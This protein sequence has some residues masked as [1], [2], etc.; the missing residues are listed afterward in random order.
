MDQV[1]AKLHSMHTQISDIVKK[2]MKNGNCKDRVLLW[3]RQAVALN[4]D[5]QKMFTQKPVASDGFILNYI[6]L[7]LILCKPF[8]GNFEKYPNFLSKINSFYLITDDW[9]PKG[10]SLEKIEQREEQKAPL[11]QCIQQ[12]DASLGDFSGITNTSIFSGGSSLMGDSQGG[13]KLAPPNFISDCF[14]LV[15]ILI[16]YMTQKIEKI[17]HKNNDDINKAIDQKNMEQLNEMIASKLCLDVHILGK[18]TLA[19]YRSLFTFSNALIVCAGDRVKIQDKFFN[20]HF[21]F[22]ENCVKPN[23]NPESSEPLPM[24]FMVLPELIFRNLNGFPKLFKNIYPEAYY[25]ED[26]DLHMQL[27][28]SVSVIMNRRIQNPHMRIEFL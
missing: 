13:S 18:G 10:T 28:G 12:Q 11:M 19:L 16:S 5:K 6:D 22:L 26:L 1:S 14:F 3:M 9:V 21:S 17:Y 20:S 2:L 27:A 4:M 23:C 15:H 25:C 24:D 7:L 8:I